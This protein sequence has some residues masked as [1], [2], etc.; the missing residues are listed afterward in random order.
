VIANQE[1]Q[2]NYSEPEQEHRRD[3]DERD[4]SPR[5]DGGDHIDEAPARQVLQS[6]HE[7]PMSGVYLCVERQQAQRSTDP[8]VQGELLTAVRAPYAAYRLA[9]EDD[10][11]FLTGGARMAEVL[12][13]L[14][15][16]VHVVLAIEAR[17]RW[18]NP[19][20]ALP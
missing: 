4:R 7:C 3:H 12:F 9:G 6:L 20:L 2:R 1:R 10:Q 15:S 11:F 16:G 5:H 13:Q 8:P 19:A 18:S 14:R 17:V